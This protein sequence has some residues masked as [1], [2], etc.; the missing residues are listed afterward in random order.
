MGNE[1]LG[2]TGEKGEMMASDKEILQLWKN[3]SSKLKSDEAVLQFYRTA[4]EAGRK[5]SL[6]SLE[7]ELVAD[8]NINSALDTFGL[9][10]RNKTSLITMRAMLKEVLHLAAEKIKKK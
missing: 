7:K 10:R 2:E 1:R 4:E 9:G 8:A 3:I 5:E 6:S